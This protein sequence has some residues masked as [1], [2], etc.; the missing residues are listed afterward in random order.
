MTEP[1]GHT[2]ICDDIRE[3]INGKITYVGVYQS[4]LIVNVPFPTSLPMLCFGVFYNSPRELAHE[5]AGMEIRV[6]FPGDSE[7][8][9][10]VKLP[11]N[12]DVSPEFATPDR[13]APPLSILV[14]PQQTQAKFLVRTFMPPL[15][16]AGHIR[17]RALLKS[18]RIVYLGALE[19]K[20]TAPPTTS[21]ALQPPSEQSPPAAS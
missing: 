8:A 19:V 3:E 9:P 18:G 16:E 11:G 21:T 5:M 10:T 2:V 20:S 17:V 15:K 13:S 7:D 14:G 6:Y 4:D 1:Y 12:P